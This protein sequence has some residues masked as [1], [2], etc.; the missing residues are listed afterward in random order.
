MR[1]TWRCPGLW[2]LLAAAGL[3]PGAHAQTAP[4]P[5]EPDMA[6]PFGDA[7]ADTGPKALR[8]T[9]GHEGSL[10]T[11]RDN[12]V[13]NNRSALRVEYSTLLQE[14]FFVRLDTK[15]NAYWGSDHRARS[16]DRSV[17]VETRTP[18]AFV[19]YSAP[20][21]NTSVKLG[22]QRL[23]W[24]ESEAGAI[25]DVV[26]PRDL[27]ELFLIPLEE[28]RI[29]QPMLVVDHFSPT[30]DWTGFLVPRAKFNKYPQ[31]GTAYH[32]DRFAGQAALRDDPG[33]IDRH[34]AGMRWK[35][36]SNGSDIGLMLASVLDND[37]VYRLDGAA[38]DG[39]PLLSSTAR[40]YTMG[41]MSFNHA[42]GRLL[43]KG[44]LAYKAGKAFNDTGF[45]IV[46]RDVIDGSLSMTW[47]LMQ[48]DT[49][50]VELVN[51]HVRDWS[52]QIAGFPR[53]TT[54]AVLNLTFLFLNDRLSVNW[55]SVATYPHKALQ[56]SIRSAYKASDN[57][58]LS[59]DLHA[60]RSDDPRSGLYD[61]RDRGQAV[62]RAQYQF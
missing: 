16:E 32:I 52:P 10:Y 47:P 34:E 44:E 13:V 7:L 23:I 12:G 4:P 21:G 42:R 57:L 5:A 27:S 14:G 26:S 6:D 37:H 15:L 56:S 11:E 9:L 46:R 60:I 61:V 25:T 49:L 33:H 31:A 1:T 48:A 62:L 59:L 20:G 53:N 2:L 22:V 17:L 45:G 39:R 51:S 58:T 30:G 38:P 28:S 50:N 24:G 8:L 19:Q 18:E 35:R 40:R 54:S 29:G 55:L 41:G 3:T 36:T 43:L